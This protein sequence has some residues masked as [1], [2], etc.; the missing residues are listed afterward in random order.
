MDLSYCTYAEILAR[1]G[2]TLPQE[3][4]EQFIEDADG[5]IDARLVAE[6]YSADESDKGLKS[7]AKELVLSMIVTRRR[8]DGSQPASV[9]TGSFSRSD[10]PDQA[11]AAHKAKA[12]SL[13]TAYID[14]KKR[15]ASANAVAV[16]REDVDLREFHLDKSGGYY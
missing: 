2:T 7:A 5:E 8:L 11:I 1:S 14:A 10:S 4:V 15:A 16:E 12:D 9:S 13:I 6:G 3:T